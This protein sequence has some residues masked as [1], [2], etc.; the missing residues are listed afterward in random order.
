MTGEGCSFCLMIDVFKSKFR[1]SILTPHWTC[2]F[3]AC[4]LC[5]RTLFLPSSEDHT[6]TRC[7]VIRDGKS[8]L[9]KVRGGKKV[10]SQRAETTMNGLVYTTNVVLTS[11]WEVWS[12]LEMGIGM[13]RRS[14]CCLEGGKDSFKSCTI[15][16][17]T[18]VHSPQ[19]SRSPKNGQSSQSSSFWDGRERSKKI[20]MT[21]AAANPCASY[22]YHSFVLC[23]TVHI[24]ILH[25]IRSSF[26]HFL[27][28]TRQLIF[29]AFR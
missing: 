13:E 29:G 22:Y 24:R 17:S 10:Q 16:Q 23:N 15:Y 7:Y 1:N 6:D 11:G 2:S 21:I 18:V 25:S 19:T 3:L 20:G 9:D 8:G 28:C 14:G 26:S 4:G 27:Y 12:G 5:L